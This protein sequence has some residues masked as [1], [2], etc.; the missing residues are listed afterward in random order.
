M[1]GLILKEFWLS[2]KLRI[3][4]LLLYLLF[5]IFTVLVK[6]SIVYGNL[7]HLDEAAQKN[8]AD[9]AA[10]V[11][12]F[13]FTLMLY[14]S[15]YSCQ[16]AADGK[17][18]FR[19]YSFT[20]P[21]SERQIVSSVYILNLISFGAMTVLSFVNYGLSC[22]IFDREFKPIYLIYILAIGGVSFVFNH[23]RYVLLYRFRNEKKANAIFTVICTAIYFG[24]MLGFTGW[25]SSYLEKQGYS[26]GDDL[27]DGVMDGFWKDELMHPVKWFEDNG[28]WV[29]IAL[30][31][32]LSCLF[33]ALSIRALKRREN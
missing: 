19:S 10:A 26:M 27:P 31:I 20:L 1:K 3:I 9:T 6:L 30:I 5:L 8:V 25:T 21:V 22:L 14:S 32:G 17:C 23:G 18:R 28:W 16:I 4:G 12:V 13:G 11:M 15:Q 7:G 2:R 24:I 29:L 33:W